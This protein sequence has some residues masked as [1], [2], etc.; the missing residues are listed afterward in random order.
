MIEGAVGDLCDWANRAFWRQTIIPLAPR[1]PKAFHAGAQP[2]FA[3]F[4]LDYDADRID[5]LAKERALEWS[6]IGSAAFLTVDEQREAAGYGPMGKRAKYSADQPR[7]AAGSLEGG[8]WTSG[9]G[10]GGG[11]DLVQVALNTIANVVNDAGEFVTQIA[12]LIDLRDEEGGMFGGHAIAEHVGKSDSYLENRIRSSIVGNRLG[13]EGYSRAGTFFSLEA[14]NKLVNSTLAQKQDVVD[15]VA[16]GEI[17]IRRN[18]PVDA[19]FGSPT[20]REAFTERPWD[21]SASI[22][23]RE[24]FGVG[25]FIRHNPRSIKGFS[26]ISAFPI[27]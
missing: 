19:R 25:V 13:G 1:L 27:R 4:R 12:D 10:S 15:Q 11:G 22:D 7:V 2:G 14:A 9:D 18:I 8:Q 3:P 6:R 21:P 5:A 17:G 23:F 24:T 26:I 16:R 20:G